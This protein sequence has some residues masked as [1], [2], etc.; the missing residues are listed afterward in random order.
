M[1]EL[2]Y[3]VGML[4]D[5]EDVAYGVIT[6]LAGEGING[7][8]V[9][10]NDS[11]DGTRAELERAKADLAAS[12]NFEEAHCQ[13]EIMGDHE[14]GY[15]QSRKMTHLAERAGSRGATWIVPFDADELWHAQEHIATYLRS[16]PQDV[17]VVTAE[18]FN[19]FTTALDA[20]GGTPFER[21]VWRQPHSG[22]LPKVAF[23]WNRDTVIHQ[24]NHGVSGAK[25]GTWPGL[26][27]RHFP[28]RSFE[29]FVTKARNGAAAYAAT[30]LPQSEGAHWRGYGEILERHGEGALREVYDRYFSFLSPVDEGM[31]RDPA[32]YRRWR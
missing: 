23:R 25:G 10:D 15:F 21:M 24:G 32:P 28:Y 17:G 22:A 19:H 12:D 20:D 16:V 2:V 26:Q 3:A 7:I 9:A 31:V 29:H 18:L 30:D 1:P 8:L 4:K 14:I 11:T 5:E 6:H 27:I 13:I